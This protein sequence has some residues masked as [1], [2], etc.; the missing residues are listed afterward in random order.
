M[1]V[2]QCKKCNYLCI[3]SYFLLNFEKWTRGN[4]DID[5]FIQDIQIST[6]DNIKI[7]WIPYNRLY[8]VKC[9]F[10]KQIGLMDYK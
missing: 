7:E 9:V 8:N 3:T 4:Y 1:M 2:L 5:K 6:H 10:K